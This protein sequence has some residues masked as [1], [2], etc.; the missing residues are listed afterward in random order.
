[1]NGKPD[2][3]PRQRSVDAALNRQQLEEGV[4][5]SKAGRLDE[6]MK[7]FQQVLERTPH[8][9]DALHLSG[10]V[11]AD[12][13][14]FDEAKALIGRALAL[15]PHDAAFH[16][17]LGNALLTEGCTAQAMES[18]GEALRLRP[19]D[20]DV[21]SKLLLACDKRYAEATKHY[22]TAELDEADAACRQVLDVCPDR[23][24]AWAVWGVVTHARGD[25]RA[26]IECIERAIAMAPDDARFHNSYRCAIRL[27]AQLIEAHAN[28]ASALLA[29]GQLQP[30][31]A[32]LRHVIEHDP[33]DVEAHA[34]LSDAL[35]QMGDLDEAIQV[36]R[37]AVELNPNN[38][39]AHGSLG[40]SLHNARGQ[41]SEAIQSCR[42][43]L[44]LDPGSARTHNFLA[45][46]LKDQGRL[47]EALSSYRQA[48]QLVPDN[49]AVHSNILLNLHYVEPYDAQ[50]I[51]AQ[52][53][54]WDRR[55]GAPASKRA[56][57]GG[58]DR[59]PDRP[60]RIGYVSGDLK[61]HSVAFFFEPVLSARDRRAFEVICYDNNLTADTTT[62][63]LQALAD[64]W[65]NIAK[66]DDEQAES[67]IRSDSIDILVDLAGHSG[68]NRLP[69]FTR[70]P[71]PIQVTYLGYPDTTG[72]DAI[73]YRFTDGWADP[74]GETEQFHT[75]QLARL[76]G[77]F[78]CYQPLS[79]CPEVGPLPMRQAGRVTFG[80]FNNLAKVSPTIVGHW[81]AI[82]SAVPDSRLLLKSRAL[83]D[84]G[85]REHVHQQFRA[86]GI[87]A[88]RVDL[89]SWTP[90]KLEHMSLYGE[91]DVALDTFP[92][93]GATTTCEALWMGVPV[94]TL[95]GTAHVSRVGVSLLHTAGITEM[96]T[97]SAQEYVRRAVE[98]AADAD[99]LAELRAALRERLRC[100]P[101]IDADRIARSIETAYRQMWRRSS[102]PY[103]TGSR[104]S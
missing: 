71:A 55:H 79:P 72:I 75:E 37:R 83:A 56:P 74:P 26:G 93:H 32:S 80:S 52:H 68:G 10:V 88:A 96:I 12:R 94:V 61:A 103:R 54:D 65:R 45:Q 6:A 62:E 97:D 24:D 11:A 98:L 50:A 17:S 19:G 5:H 58:G 28:L 59:D 104:T 102:V 7:C 41:T 27:D 18:Y 9:A 15:K 30:A 77:G 1:M 2:P 4:R 53:R 92:Y 81:A 100:S 16:L 67:L 64:G 78:L 90:N 73:D 43:S 35:R 66:L 22:S 33:T 39:L 49:A 70:K 20:T 57:S 40:I 91:I 51:F 63:R 3:E 82:L 42:R 48:L 14:Q 25:A 60:L 86:H 84:N 47:K 76:R 21:L 85:T 29:L 8:D 89:S 36:A 87:E 38:A 101:L 44:E 99:R 95:A 23:A 69:L 31:I 46:C 13:G 34:A